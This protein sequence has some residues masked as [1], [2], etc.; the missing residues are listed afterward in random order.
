MMGE[1]MSRIRKYQGEKSHD[2]RSRL[3]REASIIVYRG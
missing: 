1:I 2:G 3:R